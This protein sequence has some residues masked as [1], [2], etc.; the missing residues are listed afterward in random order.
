VLGDALV[1]VA[2]AALVAWGAAHIVPTGAVIRGFPALSVDNRRVLAMEWVAEGLALAFV[3][4]LGL[5]VT[6]SAGAQ[7]ALAQRVLWAASALLL[8]MAGWT[9]LTGAR[10]SIVPIRVCPFVLTSAAVLVVAGT[11]L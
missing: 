6:A 10:T 1:Y 11:L 4:V 9:A 3:G 8:V 5:V 2:S 7:D